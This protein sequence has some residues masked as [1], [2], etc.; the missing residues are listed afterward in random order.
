M[1]S[2]KLGSSLL[3]LTQADVIN[4]GLTD[5][6]IIEKTKITL[7]AHG[8]NEYQM[9]PKMAL[10]P[11]VDSFMH[12]MPG[13]VPSEGACGI[14]WAYCF[15]ENGKRGLPQLSG[16]VVINC[17]ETGFPLCIM[18]AAWITG[19]RTAAITAISASHLARKDTHEIGLIGAGVQGLEQLLFLPLVLPELKTI[20]ITDKF[21]D[22]S[23]RL[24]AIIQEKFP[25][26][27]V[28]VKDT[29]EEVVRGSQLIVSA[30]IVLA[31]PN[32]GVKD[33]WI[34][35]G[36][37]ICPIDRNS[38]WEWD[39]F[40]GVDKFV[41][42]SEEE[43]NFFVSAGKLPKIT[44]KIHA[45]LGEIEAGLK[46]GRENDTERILNLNIGMGIEDVVV[47][48]EV[49]DLAQQAELGILLPL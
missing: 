45:Q 38:M 43:F 19:K 36:T 44:P 1:K 11:V 26:I 2:P 29:K 15:P 13:Y 39:T 24:Q 14:K 21:K 22:S 37:L 8:T 34:E 49:F 3:Y 47:G 12:S 48:K 25:E 31:Q 32:P 23:L 7:K 16:V 41:I 6:E 42:D 5:M 27:N 33:E 20:K 35:P 9:P 28:V 30:T 10:Y 46:P 18:D 4:T 17:P 40:L